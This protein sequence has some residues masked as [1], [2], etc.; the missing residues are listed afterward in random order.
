MIFFVWQYL[1][2]NSRSLHACLCLS[3]RNYIYITVVPKPCNFNPQ[4]QISNKSNYRFHLNKKTKLTDS[5]SKNKVYTDENRKLIIYTI[6]WRQNLCG[7]CLYRCRDTRV[8]RCRINIGSINI[9]NYYSYESSLAIVTFY[10][11]FAW[12]GQDEYIVSQHANI[13]PVA[14]SWVD[15]PFSCETLNG[16]SGLEPRSF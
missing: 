15:E 5:S 3:W 13:C 14:S 11:H 4:I 2:Y 7:W 10:T 16:R 12:E 6:K 1:S 8:S 9:A